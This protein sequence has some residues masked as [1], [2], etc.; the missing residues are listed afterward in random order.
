MCSLVC[1]QCA[2]P[3]DES[4]RFCQ[5]CGCRRAPFKKSPISLKVPVNIQDIRRRKLELTCRRSATPYG[6]QKSALEKEFTGFLDNLE[7]PLDILSAALRAV[8]DFL[9]WKDNFVKTTVH[10]QRC[11]FSGQKYNTQCSCPKRV[12]YGSK[13]SLTGKVRSIFC[14]YGRGSDE[15]P[16]PGYGNPAASK[17]VK[18]Y[19]SMVREEQLRAR[20]SPTQAQPFFIADLLALSRPL[21]LQRD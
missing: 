14:L 16:I 21:T 8:V 3:N 13:D 11:L 9:I 12:A 15:S 17:V 20:I 19:L 7:P 1:P 6:K 10:Q 5:S 2:Y 18:D 4:F